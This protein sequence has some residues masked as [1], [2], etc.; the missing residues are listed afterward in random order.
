VTAF[1]P[2]FR[3]KLRELI[4]WRRDA[5]RFR[6]D[7]LPTGTVD[8]LLALASLAPS[9]LSQPGALS[10]STMSRGAAAV[11]AEFCRCND[12]ALSSYAGERAQLYARLKLAGLDEAPVHLALF[13][14]RGTAQGHGLGRRTMS[15]MAEYSAVMA[16]HILWLVARGTR[17]A[18]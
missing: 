16:V 10:S 1:D 15:E 7:A 11:R 12:A 13:A 6:A 17:G 18:D 8:R 5:R 2:D 14:D 4:I 3:T 9:R